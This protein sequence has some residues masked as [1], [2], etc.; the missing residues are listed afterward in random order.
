MSSSMPKY[1]YKFRR[2]G[3]SNPEHDNDFLLG[4]VEEKNSATVVEP[5]A[6]QQ[7]S[8]GWE[9]VAATPF[10]RPNNQNFFILIF[11]REVGAKKSAAQASKAALAGRRGRA[12]KAAPQPSSAARK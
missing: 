3:V 11:K 2:V 10:T 4:V 12:A 1:E 9:I 7:G 8:N 6:N 5:Y